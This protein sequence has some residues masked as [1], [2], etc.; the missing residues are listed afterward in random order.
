M[1]QPMPPAYGSVEDRCAGTAALEQL[2]GVWM[3]VVVAM[4]LSLLC[5]MCGV[6]CVGGTEGA[7]GSTGR[8]GF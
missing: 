3:L 1:A 8:H 5:L 7:E 6:F 2:D 4:I